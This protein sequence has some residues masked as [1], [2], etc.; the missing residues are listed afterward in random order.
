[1]VLQEPV[2]FMHLVV[3]MLQ[4]LVVSMVLVLTTV[5]GFRI[6][7]DKVKTLWNH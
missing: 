2:V 4:T 6:K 1:V 3:V 7:N 5:G